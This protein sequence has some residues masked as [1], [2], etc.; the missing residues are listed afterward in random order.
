MNLN[1]AR[2]TGLALAQSTPQERGPWCRPTNQVECEARGT[3][4][5][6]SLLSSDLFRK[7]FLRAAAAGAAE[8]ALPYTTGFCPTPT[9]LSSNSSKI[10]GDHSVKAWRVE[11]AAL[12]C[13]SPLVDLVGKAREIETNSDQSFFRRKASTIISTVFARRLCP[14]RAAPRRSR[15]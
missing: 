12:Q 7:N 6:A 15:I 4:S 13:L 11:I 2:L 14:W 9:H 10:A 3:T 5:S 1:S 8:P